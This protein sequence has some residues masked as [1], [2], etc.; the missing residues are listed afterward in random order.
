MCQSQMSSR[1]CSCVAL[2]YRTETESKSRIIK[3]ERTMHNSSN[4]ALIY[5]LPLSLKLGLR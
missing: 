3:M 2:Q 5:S 1:K 4:K